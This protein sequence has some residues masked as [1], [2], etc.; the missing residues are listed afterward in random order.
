MKL[1]P[2]K[3]KENTGNLIRGAG[4]LGLI[5]VAGK[6]AKK[7]TD[8]LMSLPWQELTK[9]I[10]WPFAA[11]GIGECVGAYND[12]K[13]DKENGIKRNYLE[14]A[15]R[16]LRMAPIL[17]PAIAYATDGDLV[18]SIVAPAGVVILGYITDWFGKSVEKEPDYQK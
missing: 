5:G 12:Y 8:E 10:S 9:G 13:Q 2:K 18:K 7:Y 11:Y 1:N 4:A 16:I 3:L 15:G 14:H 17:S 6:F